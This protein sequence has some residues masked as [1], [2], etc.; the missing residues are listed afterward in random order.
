MMLL[1]FM[2]PENTR[3][4][5]PRP[6]PFPAKKRLPGGS[7]D[8]M[9]FQINL[10]STALG[11][12]V[13]GLDLAEPL[14]DETF[15]R[16][17]QA[18]LDHQV[19]VFRDQHLTPAQ[20]IAFSRRFGNLSGTCTTSFYCRAIRRFSRSRTKRRRMVISPVWHPPAAGGIRIYPTPRRLLG[21]TAVRA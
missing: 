4:R 12:E 21:V 18:H 17:H 13:V 6:K 19:L 10:L 2:R 14:D 5:R 16:V 3:E 7:E 11:A 15:A 1:Y 20:H 8:K 9:S